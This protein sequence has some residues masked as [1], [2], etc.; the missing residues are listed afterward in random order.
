MPALR[1]RKRSSDEILH[2]FE[3]FWRVKTRTCEERL[4]GALPTFWDPVTWAL[5]QA[6]TREFASGGTVGLAGGAR[7]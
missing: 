7:K 4:L 3:Q 2:V 1:L 5:V 6:R